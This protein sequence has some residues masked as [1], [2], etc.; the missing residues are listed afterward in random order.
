M[1]LT[2]TANDT[3][4][5]K[6]RPTITSRYLGLISVAVF[7]AWSRYDEKAIPVYLQDVEK[8]IARLGFNKQAQSYKSPGN[9]KVDKIS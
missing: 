5:F 4:R 8:E 2:A 6:P 9:F 3:E 1:A 7:D